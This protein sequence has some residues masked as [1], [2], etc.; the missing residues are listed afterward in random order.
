MM[1]F[2]LACADF[3][4]PLLSHE[5]SLD[6]IA[7]LGFDG[8][9]IGLFEGR[10]HLQPSREF[11]DRC[12]AEKL[13][14][15]VE[16]RGLRVADVYLQMDPDF[17][18]YAVNHPET[19]RRDKARDWF[20]RTLDYAAACQSPHVTALPGVLFDEESRTDSLQRCTTN[21]HGALNNRGLQ[22]LCLV[23]RLMSV[24]SFRRPTRHYN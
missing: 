10:S 18:T 9:D 6:L 19:L 13:R 12:A 11:S 2:P 21:S 8:V 17:T 15:K 24:P 7:L 1:S 22:A 14:Q 20:L 5:H 3:T 23:S 4:F 16:N